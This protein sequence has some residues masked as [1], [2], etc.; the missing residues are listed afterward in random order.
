MTV[1]A[2][3]RLI[4][5]PALLWEMHTH[6]CCITHTNTHTH[7]VTHLLL[8]TSRYPWSIYNT[9]PA[10]VT[11]ILLIHS[12]VCVNVHGA[13]G[14]RMDLALDKRRRSADYHCSRTHKDKAHVT[15]CDREPVQI[16][17]GVVTKT[18]GN[19]KIWDKTSMYI[20]I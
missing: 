18:D 8:M 7:T 17:T 1:A 9:C 16:F 4:S 5:H 14:L 20:N 11:F 12:L 6:A 15:L 10:C 13:N 3:L 2:E 19:I